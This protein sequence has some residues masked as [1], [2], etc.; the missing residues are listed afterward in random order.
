MIR[1]AHESTGPG[2]PGVSAPRFGCDFCGEDILRADVAL[3]FWKAPTPSEAFFVHTD[4]YTVHGGDC[5]TSKLEDLGL[6]RAETLSAPLATLP[7]YL[8][9]GANVDW[10]EAWE[11]ASEAS[12]QNE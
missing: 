10:Y 7:I 8:G 9:E 12:G 1:I 6:K 3:Y 4:L 2:N 11:Q 5:H